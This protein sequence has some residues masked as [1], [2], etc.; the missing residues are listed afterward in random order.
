VDF[1]LAFDF[2]CICCKTSYMLYNES[3]TS[4][5]HEVRYCLSVSVCGRMSV[6]VCEQVY[7]H[8]G[9]C[10]GRRTAVQPNLLSGAGDDDDGLMSVGSS[11]SRGGSLSPREANTHLR[12]SKA[13]DGQLPEPVERLCVVT[14]DIST[15]RNWYGFLR[16]LSLE[17]GGG[18]RFLF[19]YPSAMQVSDRCTPI[20]G[21]KL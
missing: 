13:V 3:A 7:G 17:A 2:L 20:N 4:R 15:T 16:N 18:Y 10:S 11:S 9:E 5:S 6:L 21:Y 19:T 8:V 1:L 14:G 12:S